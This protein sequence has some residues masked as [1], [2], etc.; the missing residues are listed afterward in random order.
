[1]IL[2]ISESHDVSCNY[3]CEWLKYLEAD[4]IRYNNPTEHI[5]SNITISN[6]NDIDL[7]FKFKNKIINKDTIK[8]TWFRRGYVKLMHAIP[9]FLIE[10]ENSHLNKYLNDENK[11]FI[12][13]S[14]EYFG[15]IIINNPF[16]YNSHKLFM[17]KQAIDNGLSI[18]PTIITNNR[19]DVVKFK[20]IEKEI[21]S[22]AIQDVYG[23]K[24]NG[25]YYVHRT[26]IIDDAYIKQLPECFGYSLFQK[27]IKADYELRIFFILGE[28]YSC[29]IFGDE[30]GDIRMADANGAPKRIVTY[31]LDA[32]IKEKIVNFMNASGLKSGSLDMMVKGN[33][34]YFLEVNPVGQ[35]DYVSKNCNLFIDKQIAIKLIEIDN[36]K[37]IK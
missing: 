14:Y 1:M 30:L 10:Q 33:D 34:H 18:P 35:Y 28:I 25:K 12:A 13:F 22:K 15:K 11:R 8:V 4:F 3:T 24:K 20:K 19:K 5:I 9:P 29:A 2:I 36:E 37:K 32:A 21:I 26:S 7:N 23:Y 6:K 31:D 16:H 17:L 27:R